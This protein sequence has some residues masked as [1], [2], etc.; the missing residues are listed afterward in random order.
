MYLS[1][2]KYQ[3]AGNDFI[4]VD[5]RKSVFPIIHRNNMIQQLCHRRFGIGADGLIL[6]EEDPEFDFK[7]VYFNSDGN[8][9]SMC[10]NGGRCIAAFAKDL[11][12]I[13]NSAVFNAIDG[14]HEVE[15][16][17]DTNVELHMK[18]VNHLETGPDT[19]VLNTGSPHYVV[20]VEDVSK[21]NV[22]EL[23]RKIR[24]ND[25]YT[26]DGINVNFAQWE[27]DHLLV[28]T[29][30]RGVEDETLACGTGITAAAL[31]WNE[32]YKHKDSGDIK[33]KAKGGEL[34]VKFK[35]SGDEYFDIW[36]CGPAVKVF[37]GK[38][39]LLVKV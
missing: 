16:K 24:Y 29:Y 10:G 6:L 17:S 11:N 1:F 28:N 7:M 15:L 32:L 22:V 3:G 35:K 13:Q 9:S 33:V 26:K 18:N 12:I 2:T 38:V 37:E 34:S 23:A 19:A 14:K 27:D 39:E 30:E 8:E 5:N 25:Q 4:M 21:I 36:L 31:S 20:F